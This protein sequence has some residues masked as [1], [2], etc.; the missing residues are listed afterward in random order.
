[1]T[2]ACIRYQRQHK[3]E[4]KK[5]KRMKKAPPPPPPSKSGNKTNAIHSPPPPH[6]HPHPFKKQNITHTKINNLA[7]L[8]H[9][10]IVYRTQRIKLPIA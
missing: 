7:N 6:H 10:V 3:K 1:M 8:S 2:K 5:I 9:D 4:R